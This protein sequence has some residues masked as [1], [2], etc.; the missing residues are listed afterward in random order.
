MRKEKIKIISVILP[1]SYYPQHFIS[2]IHE[3]GWLV[4]TSSARPWAAYTVCSLEV[5]TWPGYPGMLQPGV[6]GTVLR[7]WSLS[8]NTPICSSVLITWIHKRKTSSVMSCIVPGSSVGGSKLTDLRLLLLETECF[9]QKGK[10]YTLNSASLAS[11]RWP[12]LASPSRPLPICLH[13]FCEDLSVY[14]IPYSPCCIYLL[15]LGILRCVSRSSP[16]PRSAAC[17]ICPVSCPLCDEDQHLCTR[18][19]TIGQSK[20][21]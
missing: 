21:I 18:A 17:T 19:N 14:I 10:K 15:R 1:A 16:G 3:L 6:I 7:G 2:Q 4:A 8:C 12:N 20:N 11:T 9:S 5:D 13:F